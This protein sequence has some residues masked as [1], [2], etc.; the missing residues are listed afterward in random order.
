MRVIK[1]LGVEFSPLKTF[2][3]SSFAEFAKRI[4]MNGKEIT[5]FPTS[6]LK[7]CS[8]RYY[9]LTNLLMEQERKGWITTN[10][11]LSVSEFEGIVK[12]RPS[13]FRGKI[14]NNSFAIERI[15]KCMRDPSLAN[16]LLTEV[17]R[18]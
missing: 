2:I 17:A 15:L 4:F 10:I 7:E 18:H 16:T 6:A 13:R 9:M 14:Q 3:S 12:S 11:S 8:K 1:S 5:P